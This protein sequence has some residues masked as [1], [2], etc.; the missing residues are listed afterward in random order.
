MII[1]TIIKLSLSV[2]A[3]FIVPNLEI[4]EKKWVYIK[5]NMGLQKYIIKI[6]NNEKKNQRF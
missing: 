1:V 2:F 6:Y 5:L 4:E 3:L